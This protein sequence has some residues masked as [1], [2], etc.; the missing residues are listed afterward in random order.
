MEVSPGREGPHCHGQGPMSRDVGRGVERRQVIQHWWVRSSHFG[1][2]KKAAGLSGHGSPIPSY[3]PIRPPGPGTRT[4]ARPNPLE[5]FCKFQE[6][7]HTLGVPRTQAEPQHHRQARPPS[8]L[9]HKSRETLTL[10]LHT[11]TCH[12]DGP[13]GLKALPALGL[14][15]PSF[16]LPPPPWQP[17]LLGLTSGWWAGNP[18]DPVRG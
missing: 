12:L 6:P 18:S 9:P 15:H 8:Q 16:N 7:A 13:T 10:P 14:V 3:G 11:P 17:A 5:G 2:L 1:T 4:S